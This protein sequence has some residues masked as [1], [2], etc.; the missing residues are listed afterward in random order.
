LSVKTPCEIIADARK[1]VD[2]VEDKTIAD[3]AD[4]AVTGA[5]LAGD[6]VARGKIADALPEVVGSLVCR[7]DGAIRLRW[8]GM[9]NITWTTT[10]D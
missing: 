3:D 10:L 8:K 5:A 6:V 9:T 4:R 1:A 2:R 7:K